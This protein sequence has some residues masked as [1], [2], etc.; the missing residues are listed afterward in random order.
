MPQ[1]R[2]FRR[3]WRVSTDSLPL[4]AF[5]LFLVRLRPES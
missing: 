5:S 3:R 1:L 2:M 4:L